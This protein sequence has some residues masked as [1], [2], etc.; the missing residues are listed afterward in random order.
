MTGL[1]ISSSRILDLCSRGAAS[2]ASTRRSTPIST[3]SPTSTWPPACRRPR[4]GSAARRSFGGVDQIKEAH[5]DQRGLPLVDAVGQDVRFALRLM[6]RQPPSRHRGAGARSRHRREQHAVHDPERAHAARAADIHGPAACCSSRPSTIAAATAACRSRTT[7]TSPLARGT[8]KRIA[9]FRPVPMVVAGDGHAAERLDGACVTA[10]AFDRDRR[11]PRDRPRLFTPADDQPGAAGVVLLGSAW[12][13][14]YG[15]DAAAL[16]RS[17]T[18]N[19]SAGHAGRG[20]AQID[21]A[22]PPPRRVWMPLPTDAGP[23]GRDA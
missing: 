8:T 7:R 22:F 12:T 5:R 4:R 9:A 10:N 21:P 3:C 6:H 16:G 14:R 15:D 17:L 11:P 19:G 2:A 13:A 23:R 20:D 1:R 18:V